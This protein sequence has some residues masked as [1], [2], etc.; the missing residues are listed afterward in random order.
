MLKNKKRRLHRE[1]RK[2]IPEDNEDTETYGIGIY[3]QHEI[4]AN[5][6]EKGNMKI[7]PEDF[8]TGEVAKIYQVKRK[9]SM[10]KQPSYITQ[11]SAF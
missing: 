1:K 2:D 10:R 9:A 3:I 11:L 6:H 8:L 5:K 7:L 4:N